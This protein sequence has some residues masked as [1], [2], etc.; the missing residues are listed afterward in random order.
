LVEEIFAIQEEEINYD[1]LYENLLQ[2]YLN[3]ININKS[4]AEELQ[5]LYLLNP[6]QINSL[7]DYRKRFGPLLSLYELQAVPEFDL[8]LIYRLLPFVSLEKEGQFF[9]RSLTERILSEQNAYLMI[10]HR[11]IWEKRQGFKAVD[12]LSGR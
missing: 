2:V 3:P 10:R 12:T 5:A 8:E 9:S 4:N 1:E 11:R 7:L 6:M